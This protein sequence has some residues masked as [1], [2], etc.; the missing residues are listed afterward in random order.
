MTNKP[1]VVVVPGQELCRDLLSNYAKAKLESFAAPIW[2]EAEKPLDAEELTARLPGAWGCITSWGAPTFTEEVLSVADKLRII[3]HAAGSVKR[4]F[5][6]AAFKRGI[7]VVNAAATIADSVA[8]FTLAVMLTMQRDFQGYDAAI[9]AGEKWPK[10]RDIHELYG[11]RVGIISASMV[12]RRVIHLLEPFHTRILVY[13]PYLPN[14]EAAELGVQLAPLEEIMS[15]CDIISVHAPVTDET[16]GMITADHLR[17]LRDDAL[18]VNT[19][20]AIIVDYDA[21]CKELQSGRIRAALDVFTKEPLPVD[22]PFRGLPNVILTPHLAG[23]TVESRLRLIETV[24]DDF[25]RFLKGEPLLNRVPP[26]K[27]RILA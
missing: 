21:L 17:M 20:R 15:T 18:F 11:K 9:K 23:W 5:Y 25:E 14:E 19:A 8:E 3:G 10:R 24:V 1:K 12:G 16:V 7:T 6:P 13:D 4:Y 27:I 22:S 2:N 26:E